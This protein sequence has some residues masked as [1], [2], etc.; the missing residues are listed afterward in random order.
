M[1]RED[2]LLRKGAADR[3]QW[4]RTVLLLLLVFAP[5]CFGDFVSNHLPVEQRFALIWSVMLWYVVIAASSRW[6]FDAR[7]RALGLVCNACNRP[8]YNT[9]GKLAIATGNCGGCGAA[10]FDNGTEPRPSTTGTPITKAA[11]LRQRQEFSK[12]FN[13]FAII[14]MVP[15]MFA[16]TAAR[17]LMEKHIKHLPRQEAIKETW[18][19]MAGLLI[20]ALVPFSLVFAVR[21]LPCCALRCP[22]CAGYLDKMEVNIALVSGNCSRCGASIFKPE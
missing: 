6:W 21:K 9:Y 15:G 7:A 17:L 12:R 13:W 1:T 22:E 3:G 5:T 20:V 16:S 18:F 4:V 14:Y 11:Y 19:L 10:L 8:L 2:F